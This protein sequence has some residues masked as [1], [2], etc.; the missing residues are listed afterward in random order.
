MVWCLSSTY[1]WT[2]PQ[3]GKLVK[4]VKLVIPEIPVLPRE[5][6]LIELVSIAVMLPFRERPQTTFSTGTAPAF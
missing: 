5:G 4:L 6:L 2:T 3:Y 1:K